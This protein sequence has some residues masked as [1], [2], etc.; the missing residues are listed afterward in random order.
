MWDAGCIVAT[1]LFFIIALAYTAG[2][3]KLGSKESN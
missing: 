2:C 1:V 3:D